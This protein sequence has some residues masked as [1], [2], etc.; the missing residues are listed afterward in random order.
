DINKLTLLNDPEKKS[1]NSFIVTTEVFNQPIE[2]IKEKQPQYDT[3]LSVENN[4]TLQQI[5]E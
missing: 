3:K 5:I 1:S 4:E 2:D